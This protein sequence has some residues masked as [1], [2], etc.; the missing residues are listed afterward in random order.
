M[1]LAISQL[2]GVFPNGSQGFAETLLDLVHSQPAN[3]LFGLGI[4]QWFFL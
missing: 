3:Q 1:V 2:A 4:L